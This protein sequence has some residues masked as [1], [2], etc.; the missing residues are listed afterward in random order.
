MPNLYKDGMTLWRYMKPVPEPE[1]PIIVDILLANGPR[2]QA[3]ITE[4]IEQVVRQDC[5]IIRTPTWCAGTSTWTRSVLLTRL[6]ENPQ[7]HRVNRDR[8]AVLPRQRVRPIAA[9]SRR[10]TR[11]CRSGTARKQSKQH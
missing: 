9:R 7:I 3:M 6:S 2:H 11:C 8:V 10:V 5:T 1:E 4:A